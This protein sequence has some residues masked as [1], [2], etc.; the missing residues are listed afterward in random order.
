MCVQQTPLRHKNRSPVQQ[1]HT[2]A[3]DVMCVCECVALLRADNGMFDIITLEEYLDIAINAKRVV[4]AVIG[5]TPDRVTTSLT[6]IL[7]LSPA[8]HSYP[9]VLNSTRAAAH[10]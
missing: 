9:A 10:A 6:A 1:L 5:P 3:P 8:M 4:G 7:T 2:A